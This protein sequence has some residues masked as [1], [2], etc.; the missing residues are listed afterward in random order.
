L[1]SDNFYEIVKAHPEKFRQLSCKGLLF[2]HYNCPQV[3]LIKEYYSQCNFISYTFSGKKRIHKSGKSWFLESEVAVFARKG[4]YVFEKIENV[5][6][7]VM[8][9]FIPDSYLQKIVKEYRSQLPFSNESKTPVD[10]V[11]RLELSAT[12]KVFFESM[13]SYFDNPPGEDILELKFKEL[14]LNL[15]TNQRNKELLSILD[16][17]QSN[18]RPSLRQVMEDNYLYNLTLED[19]AKISLRSLPTFKRDFTAEFHT[20]PGKWLLKKRLENANL[21]L[22]STPK[23]VSDIAFES[24]FENITHFSRVFKDQYGMSPVQYRKEHLSEI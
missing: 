3:E 11:V 4:A 16:N 15:I 21:L 18:E 22:H 9:F 23:R 8:I 1:K 10:S 19:L 20:T 12:T 24:G 7:C 2:A 6:H 17:I 14:L 5:E 13:I